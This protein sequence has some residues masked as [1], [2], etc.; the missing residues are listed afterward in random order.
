MA[1]KKVGNRKANAYAREYYRENENYRKKKIRDRSKYYASHKE[2]E[3]KNS[4]D[5][6]WKNP[7]YRAYKV[8]YARKYRASHNRKKSR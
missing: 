4:R 3:A 8:N 2:E 7:E 6:Y 5:Y 1:I